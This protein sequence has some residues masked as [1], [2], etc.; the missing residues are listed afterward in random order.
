MPRTVASPIELQDS[1]HS[2]A[3]RQTIQISSQPLSTDVPDKDLRLVP[4]VG[5]VPSG[6]S[7]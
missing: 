2:V 5:N 4:R 1:E 7:L 6:E 3:M